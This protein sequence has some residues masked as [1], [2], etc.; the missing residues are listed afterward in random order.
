MEG[1]RQ[2]ENLLK[3]IH[4]RVK[5]NFAILVSLI[6]MQMAQTKNPELLKSLTNLQLRIR[7]MALVHEMLYR[8]KDFEN[9]SFPDYLRSLSSVIAGTYNRRDIFLTF[10]ADEI[11]M[12]IDAAIPVGLIVNEILS[13]SYLHAFPDNRSGNIYISF[14]HDP[15]NNLNTLALKDDGIGMLAGANHDQ[16]TSMGLQIIQILCKQIEGS[17]V[18]TNNPGACYTIAFQSDWKS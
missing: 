11:V 16:S 4:H 3:E 6:N 17:L 5:N 2:K 18:L 14:K 1:T 15:E 13:N 8:S 7:T 9:I 12:D 10:E